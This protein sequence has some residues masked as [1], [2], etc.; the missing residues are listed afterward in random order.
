MN[1]FEMVK[2]FNETF[3]HEPI[4]SFSELTSDRHELRQTLN[5]EEWKETVKAHAEGHD[6]GLLDGLVDMMYVLCG[7]WWEVS[8]EVSKVAYPVTPFSIG[9][10]FIGHYIADLDFFYEKQYD[11][12]YTST[13]LDVIN[14]TI[15]LSKIAFGLKVFNQAFA[16]VHRSNMAKLWTK[17]EAKE[18][19]QVQHGGLPILSFRQ[20]IK[21]GMYIA[22][23]ADGKIMKPPT[24]EAPN[25]KQFLV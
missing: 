15:H 20:S 16:E 18:Y 13:V 1:Y 5:R 9:L 3:G 17:E 4:G 11:K 2:E 25:L 10:R 22:T 21:P 19:S 23:R 7:H 14:G 24:W 6:I 12:A 8:K